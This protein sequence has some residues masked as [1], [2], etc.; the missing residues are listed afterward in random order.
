MF[1]TKKQSSV[2]IINWINNLFQMEWKP[3][4]QIDPKFYIQIP[5]F[6]QELNVHINSSPGT[7]LLC[8]EP[9]YDEINYCAVLFLVK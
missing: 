6:S 2:S 3:K 4:V 9:Q 1:I 7:L 8:S 5:I